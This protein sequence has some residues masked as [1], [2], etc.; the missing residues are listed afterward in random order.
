MVRVSSII[1]R[2]DAKTL[3][4]CGLL[5]V[6]E[7]CVVDTPSWNALAAAPIFKLENQTMKTDNIIEFPVST[8]AVKSDIESALK[9]SA[10]QKVLVRLDGTEVTLSGTVHSWLERALARDAAWGTLGVSMVVDHIV[11]GS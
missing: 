7:H 11:V 4:R 9:H 6:P 3:Q 10:V 5:P 1:S 2:H 8:M